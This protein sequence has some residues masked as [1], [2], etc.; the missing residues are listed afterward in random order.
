[1]LYY[2]YEWKLIFQ[3]SFWNTESCLILPSL[4]LLKFVIILIILGSVSHH[5]VSAIKYTTLQK[6]YE[7]KNQA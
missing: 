1:M 6:S 7:L 3:E 4:L 2:G 5:N